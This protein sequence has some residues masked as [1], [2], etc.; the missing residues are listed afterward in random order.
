MGIRDLGYDPGLTNFK[1]TASLHP[2]FRLL[3][4][5]GA[6][7]GL[8]FVLFLRERAFLRK[9]VLVPGALWWLHVLDH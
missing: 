4:W 6:M 9:A 5:T 2:H 3:V 8:I 1:A 7:H